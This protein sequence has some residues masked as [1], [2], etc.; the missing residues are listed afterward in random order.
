MIT[1]LSTYGEVVSP[2]SGESSQP[3]L[4]GKQN[5]ASGATDAVPAEAKVAGQVMDSKTVDAASVELSASHDVFSAV[6]NFYNLGRSGRFDAF[7]KLSPE[8]KEQFVKMVA[9]LSKS[10]YLGYQEFIV[11]HKVERHEVVSQIGDERLR[12]AHV[13]DRGR[14]DKPR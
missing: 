6:D 13:F 2:S 5:I 3:Q 1:T 12:N 10:G 7:H 9:E 8:D 11:N 14:H 4:R